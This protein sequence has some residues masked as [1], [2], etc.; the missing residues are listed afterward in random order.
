MAESKRTFQSAKMDKDVDDRLLPSGSYRDALNI[1]VDTS[2]DANVGAAENLK[3]NELI[4]NQNI[5]GLSAATNPNAKVVGSCAHPE[6]EKIYYFVTGD[7]ADGI[8]EYDAINNTISTIVIDSSNLSVA[9]NTELNFSTAS[10]SASITQDGTIFVNSGVGDPQAITAKFAPNTTGS[11]VNKN[12]SVNVKV[13]NAYKNG[14]GTITGSVTAS[15]PTI[16]APEVITENTKAIANTTATLAGSLTNNSVSVTAQGFYHGYKTDGSVLTISQLKNG[17]TGITR[18]TVTSS[19]IKNNFTANITGLVANKQIS[20]AAFATNSV[21]TTDGAVKTFTTS[22]TSFAIT[23]LAFVNT[24]TANTS[25]TENFTVSGTAGATYT[26]AGTVGATAPTGTHTIDGSGSATHTITIGAQ[27]TGDPIR[28]PKVTVTPTGTTAFLPTSLQAF[29]TIQQAAGAAQTYTY[30]LTP[31]AS[32]GNSTLKQSASSSGNTYTGFSTTQTAGYSATET[33]YIFP[34]AGYQFTDAS[35]ASITGLPSWA[36]ASV[37]H[38]TNSNNHTY[39]Q[40][41]I[42]ISNTPANSDAAGYSISATPAVVNT[43]WSQGLWTSTANPSLSRSPISDTSISFTG[44]GTKTT[45][46]T[47]TASGGQFFAG[48]NSTN[49]NSTYGGD[50]ITVTTSGIPSAANG[51]ATINFSIAIPTEQRAN[52][53]YAQRPVT[54]DW[55]G[56]T[57]IN[58][59][60]IHYLFTA[61]GGNASHGGG[62]AGGLLTSFGTTQVGGQALPST[63]D[64]DTASGI[65]YNITVGAATQNTTLVRVDSNNSSQTTIL[66]A[67]AGGSGGNAP[68]SG[69][70]AVAGSGGTGGSGG[71]A[72]A[73]GNANNYSQFSAG[74]GS[75][76]AGQGFAGGS[77]SARRGLHGAGG[78]GA[79]S[80]GSGLSTSSFNHQD[81]FSAAGGA[82]LSSN[83]T[84]TSLYYSQGGHGFTNA[85]QQ[86]TRANSGDAGQA[87]VAILRM[88]TATYGGAT[89]T[90]TYATN[91]VGSDTVIVWTGNGTISFS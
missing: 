87:G 23:S 49:K 20:Y 73:D 5:Y 41:S 72:A 59:V 62:G 67:I 17:G 26:L 79:T 21:G 30:S 78:G 66:N 25:G 10:P 91:T 4:A 33:F 1:S 44:T 46:D 24:T 54:I 13:P 3:G 7:T 42:S 43:T 27:G 9:N 28:N 82:G 35:S 61:G 75:G 58:P 38:N 16:T 90:G 15:Q 34:N 37:T 68:N 47:V 81:N 19:S 52:I 77:I 56:G 31:T 69:S 29:G 64:L 36:S 53:T 22:N 32:I 60:G 48:I 8:F 80:A 70:A 89:V 71:G 2:E 88:A 40:V 86:T 85:T 50:I 63:I 14:S 65:S 39:L 57:A 6:E 45:S 76:T 84:G 12:V 18:A 51:T 11:A 55:Q 74:G 83:I